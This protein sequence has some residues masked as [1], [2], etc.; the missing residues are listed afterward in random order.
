MKHILDEFALYPM[1]QLFNFASNGL[2][3]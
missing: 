2:W 3:G 1:K